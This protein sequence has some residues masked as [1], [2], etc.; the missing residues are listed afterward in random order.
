M[1]MQ[2]KEKNILTLLLWTTENDYTYNN[3]SAALCVRVRLF[4]CKEQVYKEPEAENALKNKELPR[5][6]PG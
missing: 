4:F 1:T 5:N 3:N 2:R 6:L